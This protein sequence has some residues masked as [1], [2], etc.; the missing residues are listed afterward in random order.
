[1]SVFCDVEL[2]ARLERLE[3]GLIARAGEAARRRGAGPHGF[4]RPLA[5]GVAGFADVD[6][7]LNKVA[8]LGFAGVPAAAELDAIE[9]AFAACGS[10]VQA[11]VATLADPAI[12]DLLTG[13]GYRLV[14]FENVLGC[15]PAPVPPAASD[16]EVRP[17]TADELGMW[18]DLVVDAF[19]VADTQGVASHEEFPREAVVNAMRDMAA[20]GLR[21]YLALR[22]GVPAGGASM[23]VVDGVAQ[24]TGAA[25]V[26]AHRRHGV[27]S[28]L[29][30]TRLTAAAA[31]GC[32]IAVV[33]TQ[34][35]SKSHQNAQRNG[36][37]LLYARAILVKPLPDS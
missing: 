1:M 20:A 2:A 11:E 14:S 7:P 22:N 32:D 4:T 34:P 25:T 9:G 16:V 12:G 29:L 6:S 8:G 23:H 24:L 35:G 28:A 37:D 19:A 5:G 21:H 18:F 27:Q 3:A 15:R 33:T 17:V 10:P 30:A 36:F 26:P 13:R 31:E